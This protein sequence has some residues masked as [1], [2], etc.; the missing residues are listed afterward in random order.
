MPPELLEATEARRLVRAEYDVPKMLAESVADLVQ[1][2]KLLEASR[3]LTP[4]KDDKL[5]ALVKLLKSKD[6]LGHKVLIFTEYADTARYL[7]KHLKQR[8]IEGVGEVDSGR[9]GR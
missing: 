6:A 8:G 1:L 3:K 9:K 4:K 7:E 5:E 2:A